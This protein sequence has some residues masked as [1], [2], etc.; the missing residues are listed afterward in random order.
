MGWVLFS[1]VDIVVR[2]E[3]SAVVFQDGLIKKALELVVCDGI[4][5]LTAFDANLWK[6][7]LLFEKTLKADQKLSFYFLGDGIFHQGSKNPLRNIIPE[8]NFTVVR[9]LERPLVQRRQKKNHFFDQQ[10]VL[11]LVKKGP[12]EEKSC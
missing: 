10:V 6:R 11:H 4:Y 1:F 7:K 2:S 3:D 8:R 5:L 12:E 9:G